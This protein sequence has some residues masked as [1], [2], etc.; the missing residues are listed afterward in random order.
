MNKDIKVTEKYRI[1]DKDLEY[2]VSKIQ[3]SLIDNALTQ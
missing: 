1:P 3:N 2:A